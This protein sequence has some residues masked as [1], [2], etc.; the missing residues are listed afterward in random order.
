V[1]VSALAA[2][3][4]AVALAA[5]IG[6]LGRLLGFEELPE[7]WV[8]GFHA[9]WWPAALAATLAGP[10]AGAAVALAVP[11]AGLGGWILRRENRRGLVLLAAAMTAGSPVWLAPPFFYDALAYHLGMP[12]SWLVNGSMAPVPHN[13]FSHFPLAASVLF[14]G[15]VRLG[16]PQAA[17]GLHW[18]AMAL[19]AAGAVSLARRSGADGAAWVAGLCTV[20]GWHG[21][22]IAGLAAVD[23]FV[24]LGLVVAAGPIMDRLAGNPARPWIAAAGIGMALS[25]KFPALVPVGALLLA[26]LAV[27]PRAVRWLAA[28]GIGGGVLASF[29]YVRNIVTV[30]NPVYPLLW[31]VFGGRGWSAADDARFTVIVR[32]GVHGWRSVAT[33]LAHLFDPLHGLGTWLLLALPLAILGAWRRWDARAVR[34]AALAAVLAVAGWLGTSQTTRYALVV[35]PLVGVLAAAGLPELS[36]GPRRLAA[37]ALWAAAAF[38]A[39]QYGTFVFGDLHWAVWLRGTE[40]AEAWRHAVTLH[41]PLPAYRA[42]GRLLGPG[43]RLLVVGEGRSWGCPVPYHVSSAYDT[44]LIQALVRRVTSP[45]AL[46]DALRREGFTHVLLAWDEIRRLH[47]PPYRVLAFDSPGVA[48]RWRVFLERETVGVW[49]GE[50]AEIRVLRERE[51]VPEPSGRG[52]MRAE[53]EVNDDREDP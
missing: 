51:G 52:T 40:A 47:P 38:G 30:G 36:R 46:R 29:W 42:A 34:W 16:L 10:E 17:A 7:A 25:V 14:L 3:A 23:W 4:L 53:K 41:D 12:W 8:A 1:T 37:G 27:A 13:L 22:W 9:A 33:G 31:G 19:A 32:E 39:F 43:G 35:G 48:A 45:E 6:G 11:T 50:G 5:G 28:V 24:V 15:P 26:A 49:T 44:Q 2:L 20:A 21:P 18:A